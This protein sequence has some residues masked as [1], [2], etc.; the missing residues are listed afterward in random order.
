MA[1]CPPY[2][3][4]SVKPANTSTSAA[5]PQQRRRQY[6]TPGPYIA[7]G[8]IGFAPAPAA[9]GYS[10]RAGGGSVCKVLVVL[11]FA[12]TE[13]KTGGSEA[14]LPRLDKIGREDQASLRGSS[15]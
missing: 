12:R 9:A 15:R 10:D 7:Q 3:I 5:R 8:R 14:S 4:S 13:K 1:L 11:C 6:G 2:A